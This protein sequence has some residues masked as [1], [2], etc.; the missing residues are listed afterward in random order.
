MTE[1]YKNYLNESPGNYKD[2]LNQSP[3]NYKDYL[4]AAITPQENQALAEWWR[5]PDQP[6]PK[7]AYTPSD[8]DFISSQQNKFPA[9]SFSPPSKA[10]PIT[11]V[12]ATPGT[13]AAP[14]IDNMPPLS[15][16]WGAEENKP[17]PKID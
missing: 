16:I 15:E 8:L 2:Y 11:P 1:S 10:G 12:S 4:N 13:S 5:T 7:P 17:K 9:L 6:E 14:P 3:D